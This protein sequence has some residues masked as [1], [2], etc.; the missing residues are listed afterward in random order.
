MVYLN[1]GKVLAGCRSHIIFK[2]TKYNA[3]SIINAAQTHLKFALI[4]LI[5]ISLCCPI[6]SQLSFITSCSMVSLLAMRSIK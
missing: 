2:S 4:F 1:T 6:T 3:T 5:Y